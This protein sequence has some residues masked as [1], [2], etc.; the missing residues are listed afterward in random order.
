MNR[1][2]ILTSL[3][4]FITNLN[5]QINYLGFVTIKRIQIINTTTGLTYFDQSYGSGVNYSYITTSGFPTGMNS[6][7]MLSIVF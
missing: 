6:L 1:V 4:F 2:L 3:L 7:N 5:S